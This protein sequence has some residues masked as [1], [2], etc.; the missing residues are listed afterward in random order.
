MQSEVEVEEE[1]CDMGEEEGQEI[2]EVVHIP[3]ESAL[4]NAKNSEVMRHKDLSVAE[5]R[6]RAREGNVE[7]RYVDRIVFIQAPHVL[8]LEKGNQTE[9]LT[10][11]AVT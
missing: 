5:R 7:I 10:S 9:K 11:D 2:A 4:M 1:I 6:D 3:A 8:S